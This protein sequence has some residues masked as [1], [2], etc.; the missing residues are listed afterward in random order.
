MSDSLPGIQVVDL[1]KTYR[2]PE[3]GAGLRASLRSLVH[4]HWRE[5]HAVNRVSF[6]IEPGE[7][8]GFLGPN[9]AGNWLP[10][11]DIQQGNFDYVLTKPEDAQLIVSTRQIAIW[12]L[13]DVL[14]GAVVLAVAVANLPSGLSAPRTLGFLVVL[15]CGG[16]M[17]YSFWLILTTISFRAVRMDNV[18]EL[19]QGVYAA[20][21]Y[22]IG[23]Y[24]GWLRLGLTFLVPVA[25]AV[26]VPAEALTGRLS[27][28]TLL[29]ALALA[30]ALLTVARL[31]WRYSLRHYTGASA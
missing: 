13:V 27:I 30:A 3:R 16:L 25:F 12:Q 24:P 9:G 18:I 23:I 10:L 19:F 1:H 4:R 6:S 5:V 21:R 26:T 15:V 31:F 28:Q 22:P 20:G 17:I 8:V 2:I 7:I 14:V 11:E 29:G